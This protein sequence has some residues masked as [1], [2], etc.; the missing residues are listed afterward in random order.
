[1]A[2]PPPLT[3]ETLQ[4]LSYRESD[5]LTI[6]QLGP[7]PAPSAGR[8]HMVIDQHVKC[9][10]EG[11]QFFRHT[12]I[13]NTL[14]PSGD[15]DPPHMI[16]TASTIQPRGHGIVVFAGSGS[17]VASRVHLPG[18]WTARSAWVIS[19]SLAISPLMN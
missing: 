6:G 4:Y 2:D 7:T 12:L 17:A 1:M 13:L 18:N 14:L 19:A 15:T 9:R 10:Q 11:V 16:F 8:Y 5:Q 3:R